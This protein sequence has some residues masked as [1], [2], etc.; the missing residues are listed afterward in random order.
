[1]TRVFLRFPLVALSLTGLLA[2]LP[3]VASA[4]VDLQVLPAQTP[5]LT[6]I[7]IT[8]DCAE[9]ETVELSID[10]NLVIDYV[11]GEDILS[12]P[13]A[14]CFEEAHF[15]SGSHT[16]SVEASCGNAVTDDAAL[17]SF[18]NPTV[19]LLGVGHTQFEW[20]GGDTIVFTLQAQ[21]EGLEIGVDFSEVD[22]HYVSGSEVIVDL[23]DGDYQV[24]YALS[25]ANATPAG[26]YRL[27][28]SISP[29][30][31][32]VRT[33][34]SAVTIRYAPVR[35]GAVTFQNDAGG[36]FRVTDLP[37]GTSTM[38]QPLANTFTVTPVPGARAVVAGQLASETSLE[39]RFVIVNVREAD[40]GGSRDP[41]C[42]DRGVRL[43]PG[44]RLYLR[45]R[46]AIGPSSGAHRRIRG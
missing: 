39:G 40:T 30:G 16:F 2:T 21:D 46:G 7:L 26:E 8:Y 45:D 35:T 23:G 38:V 14:P 11:A 17:A 12:A 43:H 6:C 18:A 32:L 31:T 20:S 13:R 37:S 24:T 34:E 44:P 27:P 10:N 29:D 5:G 36:S 41:G 15:G 22:S 42:R 4:D 3:S 33:Y 25:S 28:V 9:P 1:M 19:R